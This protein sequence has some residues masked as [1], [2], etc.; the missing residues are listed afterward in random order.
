MKPRAALRV[1]AIK[2]FLSKVPEK[3]KQKNYFMRYDL[4]EFDGLFNKT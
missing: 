2:Y 1:E 4:A 3:Q